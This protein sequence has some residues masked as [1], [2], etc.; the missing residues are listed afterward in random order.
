MVVADGWM[1]GM[2]IVIIIILGCSEVMWCDV[3]SRCWISRSVVAIVGF[4]IYCCCFQD[5][6]GVRVCTWSCL[7]V[8]RIV[9]RLAR[10]KEVLSVSRLISARTVNQGKCSTLALFTVHLAPTC[11]VPRASGFLFA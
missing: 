1:V 2:E 9:H 4:I 6:H 5:P 11:I 3:L 7:Q 8:N 10:A